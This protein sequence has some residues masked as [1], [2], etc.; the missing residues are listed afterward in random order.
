PGSVWMQGAPEGELYK[1]AR[2]QFAPA[3]SMQQIPA[4]PR[5]V[6]DILAK[7]NPGVNAQE[8]TIGG[9]AKFIAAGSDIVFEIHYATTGKPETDRSRVGMVLASEPPKLR[10]I[11]TTGLNNVGFVI[12]AHA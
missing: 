6:Q 5:P 2:A 11:T 10:Y 12:P 9:A 7:Y 3:D 1:P 4:G 8:F